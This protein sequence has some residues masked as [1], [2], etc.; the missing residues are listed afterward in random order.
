MN[1][2]EW[3]EAVPPHDEFVL[4]RWSMS[5]LEVQ[6]FPLH[7]GLSQLPALHVATPEGVYPERQ[8]KRHVR[9]DFVSLQLER[10]LLILSMGGFDWHEFPE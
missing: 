8:K 1:A 2:H 4:S 10:P 3:S 7:V 6:L 5:G 9:P